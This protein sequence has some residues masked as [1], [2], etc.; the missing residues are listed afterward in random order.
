VGLGY[1]YEYRVVRMSTNVT[2]ATNYVGEG[3]I[4][5]GYGVPLVENRGKIILVTESALGAA[6]GPEL[7]RLQQDLTGDGWTVVRHDVSRTDPVTAIRAMIRS[8]YQADSTRVK[9][10]FLIGH[11][12]V[13]Y[14]GDYAPDG[15]ADHR[16]AWPADAYYGDIDGNW[17]DSTVNRSTAADPRNRNIPGDGKFDPI[18]F[19]STIELQVGRVDLSN[20]PGFGLSEEELTRRYLDKDHAFRHKHFTMEPRGLIDDHFG[21]FGGEAFA[22]NGWRNFAPLFGSDAT[23]AADWLTT[24]ATQNF[25]WGFGCGDGTYTSCGG[26]ASTELLVGS[27]P[28]VA[29][30]FLFGSY[31]GDWDTPNNLMRTSLAT[32]GYTLTCAWAGR[33]HW[34]IHHMALGE[35]IGFSTRVT[36]NNS[37]LYAANGS[38]RFVHLSLLGDP[39][40]RLHPVAPPTNLVYRTDGSGGLTLSWRPSPEPVLGYALYRAP[41]AAGPYA[42]INSQLTTDTNYTIAPIVAGIYMVR[43]ATLTSSASGSYYNL[44][45][46]IFAD[47]TGNL[48]PPRL[49]VRRE[50]DGLTLSWPALY[51]SYQLETAPDWPAAA[52]TPVSAIPQ[53]SNDWNVVT[54]T[55]SGPQRFYRL[56]SP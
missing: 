13:P 50:S 14:S 39:T 8:D 43:A 6:L 24:L 11:V 19:P 15:H 20:L 47:L 40:L 2:A 3:Y 12:P 10:V 38:A 30:S 56:R 18:I 21:V 7:R 9:A 53:L 46:G 51:F 54:Q 55:W 32:P 42:R 22:V 36:Q 27:D 49:T 44:S 25:L 17:T 28:R 1:G 52:W 29:F 33:P 41:T 31:F 5:A 48:G 35:T 37:T 4:Y 45:Q 26:V 23:V 16:G 34:A